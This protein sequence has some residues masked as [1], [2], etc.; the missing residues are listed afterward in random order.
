MSELGMQWKRHLGRALAAG[1]AAA[2]LVFVPFTEVHRAQAAGLED[3]SGKQTYMA[4][5][6]TGDAV[7]QDMLPDFIDDSIPE[8]ATVVAKEVAVTDQGDVKDMSTGELVTD[9]LHSCSRQR[10]Q[11]AAGPVRLD[12][13]NQ[14]G[15]RP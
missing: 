6:E 15:R 8:N 2:L 4:T 13:V 11:G 12:Q 5:S 10:G 14:T 3:Q 7:P 1:T 9:K